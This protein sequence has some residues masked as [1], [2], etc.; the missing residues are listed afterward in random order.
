MFQN[1]WCIPLRCTPTQANLET[2]LE[3]VRGGLVAAVSMLLPPL[4]EQQSSLV[5]EE[6][7]L[8]R[9]E[10]SQLLH[11]RGTFLMA[12]PHAERTLHQHAA[13]L[14]NVTLRMMERGI[15]V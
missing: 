10:A 6:V 2:M 14:A 7:S 13:Q 5:Q 8:H 3:A 1:N 15:C 12:D 9:L 11:A 4:A